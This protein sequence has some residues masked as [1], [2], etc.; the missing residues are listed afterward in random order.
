MMD[1]LKITYWNVR[2]LRGKIKRV[3]DAIRRN[4]ASICI[5]CETR[6]MANTVNKFL[7]KGWGSKIWLSNHNAHSRR[8]III[9]WDPD[10]VTLKLISSFA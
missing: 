2:G 3:Q 7:D 1:T 4:K 9:F 8:R 6:L 10:V 5:L